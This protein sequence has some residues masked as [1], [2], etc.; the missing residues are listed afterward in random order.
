[1][2]LTVPPGAA[3]VE[4]AVASTAGAMTHDSNFDHIEHVITGL[5]R[6]QS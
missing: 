1:V 4:I 5:E 2:D 6:Y 3:L